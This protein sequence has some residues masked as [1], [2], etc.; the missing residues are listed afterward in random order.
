MDSVG[1]WY[2]DRV[3]DF[4]T[5]M[6]NLPLCSSLYT[7]NHVKMYATGIAN[8]V[9]ANYEW[10]LRSSRYFPAGQDPLRTNWVV[11]LIEAVP[12]VTQLT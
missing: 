12:G 1:R 9:T 2:R 5:A 4:C 7:R 10:S 11:P 8:W 3:E 6:R